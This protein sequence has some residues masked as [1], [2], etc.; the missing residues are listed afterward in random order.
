MITAIP[1]DDVDFSMAVV[2]VLGKG[3]RP[4]AVPF[5]PRTA[6][7]LDRYKRVRAHQAGAQRPELWLNPRG[8]ALTASAVAQIIRRRCDLAGIVRLNPHAFQHTAAAAWSLAGGNETDAMRLFG[9]RSR[10]MVARYASATADER[11]REAYKRLA[12]R[13][14]VVPTLRVGLT[15]AR[16]PR[17]CHYAVRELQR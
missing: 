4:R 12:P 17:E 9:W 2:H 8:G 11:A 7:A 13:D 16:V 15:T 3:S 6:T 14:R 1:V 10:A 5:G